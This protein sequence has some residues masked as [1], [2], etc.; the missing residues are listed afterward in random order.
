MKSIVM[1]TYKDPHF[2]ATFESLLVAY[3][4]AKEDELIIVAD[5]PDTGFALQI[6][7][8]GDRFPGKVFVITCSERQGF[9]DAVNQGFAFAMGDPLLMVLS[10]VS[11][12]QGTIQGLIRVLENH[13]EFGW[14]VGPEEQPDGRMGT[15]GG[16]VCVY[17]AEAV[18]Q[19]IDYREQ[20]LDDRY[21]FD[22]PLNPKLCPG[23]FS[24]DD[25]LRT[26][27]E[28]DFLPHAVSGIPPSKHLSSSE[29]ISTFPG[30]RKR[31]RQAL[32]YIWYTFA[33]A[34]TN[35]NRVPVYRLDE[36]CVENCPHDAADYR[37]AIHYG[38]D[39]LE[40]YRRAYS[41]PT[42]EGKS[43]P[44]CLQCGHDIPGHET[45]CPR[46]TPQKKQG[47]GRGL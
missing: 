41:D 6:N 45:D 36:G 15:F 11:V 7:R 23:V 42:E 10:N 20:I 44:A 30:Y 28:V 37:K 32:D 8:L 18:E 4:W 16:N 3:P 1:P 25:I 12:G 22:G 43:K 24:D 13:P 46:A 31:W 19:V 2:K 26:L 9:T 14:V 34:G 29:S 33:S 40:T 5:C 39:R 17:S 21:R 27:L 47:A 38:E 35:F